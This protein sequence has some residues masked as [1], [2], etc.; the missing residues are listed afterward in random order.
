MAAHTLAARGGRGRG[1]GKGP[2]WE[3]ART[4]HQAL[5]CALMETMQQ[6]SR[7]ALHDGSARREQ[8]PKGWAVGV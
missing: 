6:R 5:T 2:G 8:G 7:S 3:A 1:R 4:W